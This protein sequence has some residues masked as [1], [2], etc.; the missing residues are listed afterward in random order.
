MNKLRLTFVLPALAAASL[1]TSDAIAQ[2][3]ERYCAHGDAPGGKPGESLM[4]FDFVTTSNGAI[5]VE[6]FT[7]LRRGAP[8]V[9]S[10]EVEGSRTQAGVIRLKF[11]DNWGAQGEAELSK[12]GDGLRVVLTRTGQPLAPDGGAQGAYGEYILGPSNCRDGDR[13]DL[14]SYITSS[15]WDDWRYI[16]A[17]GRRGASAE[18]LGWRPKLSDPA[19]ITFR[20]TCQ[21]GRRA[22]LFEFC[23]GEDPRAWIEESRKRGLELILGDEETGKSYTVFGPLT[24]NSVTGRLALTPEIVAQI[25]ASPSIMLYG[26]N[27]PTNNYHGGRAAALRRVAAECSANPR[28]TRRPRR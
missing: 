8:K 7:S 4:F 1:W 14:S 6:F 27:G 15:D 5:P 12:V 25:G 17:K 9:F 2:P 20:I 19:P 11:I 22:L 23:P 21:R 13:D 26:E 28:P 18:L 3:R 16:P 24:A 10:R